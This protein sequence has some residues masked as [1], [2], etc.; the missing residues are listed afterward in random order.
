MRLVKLSGCY[1]LHV[2]LTLVQVT[3]LLEFDLC[4]F[5]YIVIEF[6]YV[7]VECLFC[8]FFLGGYG[9]AHRKGDLHPR[10]LNLGNLTGFPL[11]LYSCLNFGV[12][13]YFY[14]FQHENSE[15]IYLL[16]NGQKP[17]SVNPLL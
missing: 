15:M 10:V 4:V 8:M 6:F 14:F 16:S 17:N 5:H 13:L 9:I 7:L 12:F 11:L 2:L 3:W 1:L